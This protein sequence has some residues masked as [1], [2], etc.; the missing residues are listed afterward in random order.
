MV[1]CHNGRLRESNGQGRSHSFTTLTY[2]YFSSRKVNL[3]DQKD[4]AYS[5]G[6]S[7]EWPDVFLAGQHEVNEEVR[8]NLRW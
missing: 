4:I 2:L 8:G 7:N 1:A 6:D 3:L 5:S